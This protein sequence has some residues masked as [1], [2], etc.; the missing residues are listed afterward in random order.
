MSSKQ[1]VELEDATFSINAKSGE[2]D[3]IEARF[4]RRDFM[5]SLLLA[6][7]ER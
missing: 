1:A 4:A 7:S 6:Q 5:K 2:A 3:S